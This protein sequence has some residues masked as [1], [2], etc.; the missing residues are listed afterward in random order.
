MQLLS[1]AAYALWIM[2][3]LA[4][5]GK[6]TTKL[7]LA[8]WLGVDEAFVEQILIRLMKGGLVKSVRGAS[9]GYYVHNR[10]RTITWQAVIEAATQCPILRIEEGDP[11]LLGEAR[12]HVRQSLLPAL[13]RSILDWPLPP[14]PKKK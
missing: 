5:S 11:P 13:Q 4:A 8:K 9:G 2:R 7:R 6:P 12:T 1:Y 14:V 3:V 10:P